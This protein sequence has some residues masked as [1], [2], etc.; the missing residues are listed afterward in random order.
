[1]ITDDHG[2]CNLWWLTRH[3]QHLGCTW[4]WFLHKV[5][6]FAYELLLHSSHYWVLFSGYSY[7]CS[8]A[9][10]QALRLWLKN[11]KFL[12]HP[13]YLNLNYRD[14]ALK[15]DLELRSTCS[16]LLKQ[17]AD[18]QRSSSIDV[19]RAISTHLDSKGDENITKRWCIWRD[20][21]WPWSWH[22]REIPICAHCNTVWYSPLYN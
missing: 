14:E 3:H 1:M 2:N 7:F 20:A 6:Y 5:H 9:I 21:Q 16:F 18:N 15:R 10:V 13:R 12:D 17:K 4:N 22:Y 19:S 11:V 8:A